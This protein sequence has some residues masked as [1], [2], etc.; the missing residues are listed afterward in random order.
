MKSNRLVTQS[1]FLVSL[2]LSSVTVVNAEALREVEIKAKQALEAQSI[3]DA[4]PRHETDMVDGLILNRAMTRFGHRFY[5]E[6]VAAY[7]D[8]NGETDHA[9]LTI[10]EKATARSG[11]IIT[12]YNNR[13]KVFITAVSPASRN[14]DEQA[15]AAASRINYILKQNKKQASWTQFLN[16]DLAADEF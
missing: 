15:A 4:V 3:S 10:E 7:R 8:I 11:S 1:V 5:R 14:I 12:I 16:P 13:R 6:F 9:G 2:L